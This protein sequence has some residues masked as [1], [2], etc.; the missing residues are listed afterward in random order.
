[1]D[2]IYKKLNS[3]DKKLIQ[4]VYCKI[5]KVKKTSLDK[6]K[7]ID[8]LLKPLKKNTKIFTFDIGRGGRG[9]RGGR[10]VVEYY[11]NTE[12]LKNTE[13]VE[14]D[15]YDE[16]FKQPNDPQILSSPWDIY[17][18]NVGFVKYFVA[19][20]KGLP[21]FLKPSKLIPLIT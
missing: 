21:I 18:K 11:E 6:A 10:T 7:I 9:G 17:V 4:Q 3:M 13:D 20:S 2:D 15:D 12:D 16:P 1:M 5:K 19:I 14:D 8:E